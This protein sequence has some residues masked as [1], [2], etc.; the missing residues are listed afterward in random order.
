MAQVKVGDKVFSKN[1]IEFTAE[2][3]AVNGLKVTVEVWNDGD[4]KRYEISKSLFKEKF[5][6]YWSLPNWSIPYRP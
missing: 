5:D 4:P 3:V 2:V 6:G 1:G